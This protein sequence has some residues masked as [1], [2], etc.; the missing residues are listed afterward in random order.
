M[1]HDERTR[2]PN[3]VYFTS[4][5]QHALEEY[6]ASH[7]TLGHAVGDGTF[8]DAASTL[9][10]GVTPQDLVARLGGDEGQVPGSGVVAL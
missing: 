5:L 7:E 6:K 9:R 3:R 4:Q 1:S 2:L 10:R 8:K